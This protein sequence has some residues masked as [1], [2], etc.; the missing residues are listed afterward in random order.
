MAKIKDYNIVEKEMAKRSQK[1]TY[2]LNTWKIF[3]DNWLPK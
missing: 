2:Y 1:W 3:L